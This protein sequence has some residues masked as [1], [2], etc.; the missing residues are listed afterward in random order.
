M[1]YVWRLLGFIIC[2]LL[3]VACNSQTENVNLQKEGTEYIIDNVRFYYPDR[4]ELGEKGIEKTSVQFQ[5]A[6]EYIFYEVHEDETDNEL[7]HRNQ[8]YIGELQLDGASNIV[9]SQPNLRTGLS[10]YEITG[11][12][13]DR[14]LRFKHVAYFTESHTYIY[15]YMASSEDYEKNIKEMTVFLQSIVIEE[16]LEDK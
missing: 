4:Y 12:Y 13:I 2:C 5:S 3:L 10:V 11:S 6:D 14:N 8:L 7:D 1:K 15:G 9:V 16:I